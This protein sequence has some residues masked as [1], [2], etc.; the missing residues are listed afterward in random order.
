MWQV[1]SLKVPEVFQ[2]ALDKEG[3]EGGAAEKKR[4]KYGINGRTS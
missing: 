2:F 1:A 4:N 3:P